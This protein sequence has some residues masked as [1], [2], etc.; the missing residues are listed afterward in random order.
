MSSARRIHDDDWA[1]K[2]AALPAGLH[3]ADSVSVAKAARAARLLERLAELGP[4]PLDVLDVGCGYGTV[5]KALVAQGHRACGCDISA[6][7]VSYHQRCSPWASFVLGEADGPL[8]FPDA[9]F[10]AIM[11]SEVIEHV[12]DVRTFVSEMA[13]CLRP[14][15]RLLLTTPYHG[16]LKVAGLACAGLF[17]RHFDPLGAHLR[18][19]TPRS[20]RAVVASAGLAVDRLEGFGRFWPLWKAM[21]VVAHKRGEE[22]GRRG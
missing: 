4:P 19:F 2:I 14:R 21:L 6:E 22:A 13:R 8:P 16:R 3:L 12:L 1:R 15:G 9:R 7:L 11:C 20:L 5:L 10:D 17:E 18:F